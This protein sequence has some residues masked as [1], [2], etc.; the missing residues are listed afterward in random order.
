MKSVIV[1]GFTARNRRII[2][3]GVGVLGI[4]AA[5]SAADSARVDASQRPPQAA[6][7][8]HQVFMCGVPGVVFQVQVMSIGSARS[9]DT[10]FAI[11][12]GSLVT[13]ADSIVPFSLVMGMR[14]Q[15]S[16]SDPPVYVCVGR[17]QRVRTTSV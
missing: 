12:S 4:N 2:K 17:S 9:G 6:G 3:N 8:L 10:A 16:T 11:C 13:P 14:N 5:Y 7:D 15:S 1:L